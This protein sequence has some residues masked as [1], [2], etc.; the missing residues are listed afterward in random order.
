MSM[1][2]RC[3]YVVLLR[4]I[5]RI[6]DLPRR[7]LDDAARKRRL[8]RAL[9]ALEAD[10]YQEDPHGDLKMN[11]KAPKFDES[12]GSYFIHLQGSCCRTFVDTLLNDM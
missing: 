7:K 1:D 12:L 3:C 2:E 6:K 8:R 9:E 4:F 10:N 11:K 5:D